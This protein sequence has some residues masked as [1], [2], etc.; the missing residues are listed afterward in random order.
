MILTM[1]GCCVLVFGI[2]I[3]FIPGQELFA[4]YAGD[5]GHAVIKVGYPD[6]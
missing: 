6:N 4:C 5:G 3:G 1:A 2:C